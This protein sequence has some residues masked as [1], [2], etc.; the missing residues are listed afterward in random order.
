MMTRILLTAAALFVGATAS[1]LAAEAPVFENDYSSGD[2]GQRLYVY[3]NTVGTPAAPRLFE[4]RAVLPTGQGFGRQMIIEHDNSSGDNST[5]VI[6]W[7]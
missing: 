6:R 4:G 7:Y 1:A 5:K 2:N 3:P